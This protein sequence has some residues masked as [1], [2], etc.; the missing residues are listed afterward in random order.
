VFEDLMRLSGSSLRPTTVVNWEQVWKKHVRPAYGHWPIGKLTAREVKEYFVVLESKGVGSATRQKVRML[1][2][3][4]FDEA[5]ENGDVRANPLSLGRRGKKGI[6]N[7][8][9]KKARTLSLE[10]IRRVV[11]V[12]R[13]RS[14]TDSLV[15]ELMFFAGL[16]IGEVM[17]LQA[18]DVKLADHEL[19]IERTLSEAKGQL[20]VGPTKTGRA[21]ILPFDPTMGLWRDLAGYVKKQGLIGSA[22]LFTGP[23]GANLRPNNWRRRVWYTILADAGIEDAPSPHSGRRTTATRLNA[24]GTNTLVVKRILGHVSSDVTSG[25]IDVEPD[26]ISAA[27]LAAETFAG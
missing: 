22:F 1:L 9:P 2:H 25:Y 14:A 15:I 26:S 21:R 13:T 16:R 19:T 7:P 27:L 24:A 11:E 20:I 23:R 17:G 4:T 3:R 8:N 6:Q 10:E 12:A 18:R 5:M